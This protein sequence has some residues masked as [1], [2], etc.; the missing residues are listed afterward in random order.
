MFE[1]VG[2]IDNPLKVFLEDQPIT[3]RP[4]ETVAVCLIRAGVEHFRTTPISGSPRLP[5][6]MVG[7][8]FD[9]LVE[10]D[11]VGNLQAC[12]IVVEDGM[13][14]RRQKGAATVPRHTA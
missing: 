9:C 10:I 14:V 6:C 12:L 1:P 7:H 13:R 4:G 2:S 8:C 5:Y 3:A 11:G